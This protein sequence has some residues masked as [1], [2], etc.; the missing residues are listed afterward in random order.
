LAVPGIKG[1]G[2]LCG[3]AVCPVCV[4]DNEALLCTDWTS[5]FI[6]IHA[7]LTNCNSTDISFY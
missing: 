5:A 6:T 4:L 7:A 1:M 3:G 2:S